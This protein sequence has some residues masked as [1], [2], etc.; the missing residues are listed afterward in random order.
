MER[1]QDQAAGGGDSEQDGC[2]D[3]HVASSDFGPTTSK[4][5]DA[6]HQLLDQRDAAELLSPERPPVSA[7]A[8]DI[9]PAVRAHQLRPVFLPD[10]ARAEEVELDELPPDAVPQHLFHDELTRTEGGERLVI[11]RLEEVVGAPVLEGV[12]KGDGPPIHLEEVEGELTSARGLPRQ[13]AVEGQGFPGLRDGRAPLSF[14]AL[15]FEAE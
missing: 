2:S 12:V 7:V 14:P 3:F 10:H 9:D 5:G 11:T 4:S 8:E 6:V 13:I 15:L 1:G